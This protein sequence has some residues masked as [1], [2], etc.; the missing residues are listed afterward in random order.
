MIVGLMFVLI[1]ARERQIR[2]T[3]K[4]FVIAALPIPGKPFNAL[5]YH[6]RLLNVILI[7]G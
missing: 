3:C 6:L 4:P 7:A 5:P 2:A 1:K